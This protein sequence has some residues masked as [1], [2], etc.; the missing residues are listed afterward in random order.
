VAA[1]LRKRLET[2]GASV[3]IAKGGFGSS[4]ADGLIHLASMSADPS[5]SLEILLDIAGK[6]LP[7]GAGHFLAAT[8]MGG[9]FGLGASDRLQI[10]GVSGFVKSVAKELPDLWARVVDL[11]A[12]E[13]AERMAEHLEKELL[14]DDNLLEV[15]YAGGIRHVLQVSRA[16]L[17]DH[18]NVLNLNSESVVLLTGGA[19][20]VTALIT[21]EFAERYKCRLVLVGRSPMPEVEED[22]EFAFA[23]NAVELRQVLSRRRDLTSPSQIETACRQILAAREIRQTLAAAGEA[24][25]SATYHQLDVTNASAFGAFLDRIY[26]QY[27]RIDGVVHGAGVIDDKLLKHKSADM[28]RRVYNTKVK[29]AMTL[30]EKL[31]RN[32]QFVIFF[33]SVAA[34]FGNRGQVDYAAA[35]ESLDKLAHSLASRIEGRVVSINWGPWSGVGMVT[36]ELQRE[37][38]RLGLPLISAS[39]GVQ[40]FF[41]ELCRGD[42]ADTQ[43]AWLPVDAEVFR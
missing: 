3:E 24:G 2:A 35:N 9:G 4:K 14:A 8:A 39:A 7:A 16:N 41:D 29:S 25:A 42:R 12:N 13:G 11:D 22:R 31:H 28:F 21:K 34:V 36:P 30:A 37:Y 27:D 40:A 15:G 26:Q 1:I 19:R 33:S 10:G 23:Q 38:A 43:V 5:A 17:S 20:G 18:A 32:V 6:V